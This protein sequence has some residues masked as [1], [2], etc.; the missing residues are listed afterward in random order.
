[1]LP[2]RKR[3]ALALAALSFAT[4]RHAFMQMGFHQQSAGGH[5]LADA[6]LRQQGAYIF[7]AADGLNLACGE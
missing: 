1:M 6:V 7:T 4:A 2:R 3:P 5:E